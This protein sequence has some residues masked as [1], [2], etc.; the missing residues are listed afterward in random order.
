MGGLRS[1]LAAFADTQ[2]AKAVDIAEQAVQE[3][4]AQKQAAVQQIR[5]GPPRSGIVR[6]EFGPSRTSSWGC[7]C[8]LKHDVS[9]QFWLSLQSFWAVGELGA[10]VDAPIRACISTDTVSAVEK[11]SYG[12]RDLGGDVGQVTGAPGDVTVLGDDRAENA[13]W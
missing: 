10:T 9:L 13:A 7:D 11:V 5:D 6:T 3:F 2:E 12:L 4:V 1:A 8:F